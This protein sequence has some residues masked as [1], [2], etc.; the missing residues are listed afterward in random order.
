MEWEQY[1][2]RQHSRASLALWVPT[3]RFFRFCRAYG[4]H[5]NDGDRLLVALRT[6]VDP[7]PGLDLPGVH[8]SSRLDRFEIS[9]SDPSTPYEVTD[10]AVEVARRIEVLLAPL[11]S[12]VIDPPQADEHC[13]CPE[14]YPELW[15]DSSQ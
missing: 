3:L 5:N 10:A 2:Y 8:R 9:V 4:G 6:D 7:L 11:A 14:Y 15:S 13:V 1:L 12:L